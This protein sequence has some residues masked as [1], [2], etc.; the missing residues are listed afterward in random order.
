MSKTEYL[1]IGND[2][3][4]PDLE[5]RNTKL[6][7]EYK[8]LGFIIFIDYLRIE[9]SKTERSKKKAVNILNSLVWSKDIGQNI[10]MT[11]YRTLI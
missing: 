6:C 2:E 8:Y 1:E 4:D 7:K 9:T 11:I 5:I 3:D 10:Q